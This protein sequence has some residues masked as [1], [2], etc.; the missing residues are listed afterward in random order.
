MSEYGFR[1]LQASD[2]HLEQPIRG[3]TEIPDHLRDVIIDAPLVAA[4]R[5]F[6]TALRERVDFVILSGD[7]V[8]PRLAGPRAVAALVSSFERLNEAGIA[9]Y[10]AGGGV[11]PPD[12]WP[13]AARL[14]SG[15][16]VFPRSMT[17]EFT[18][19][20]SDKPIATILGRSADASIK[21]TPSDFQS[22]AGHLFN[23][24][25]LHGEYELS[26]LSRDHIDF[27]AMGGRHEQ[28]TLRDT[29]PVHYTGTS[30]ARSPKETG[31]RG[32]TIIHVDADRRVRTTFCPTDA[33]RFFH[34]V[35]ELDDASTKAELE[36]E[37]ISR[38]QSIQT[39]CGRPAMTTWE[40]RG[41]SQVVP[42]GKQRQLAGELTDMLRTRFGKGATPVWTIDFEFAHEPLPA[43]WHDEDSLLGD[44]VR[45]VRDHGQ[46][47]TDW[48][49]VVPAGVVWPDAFESGLPASTDQP[50][51]EARM[52]QASVLGAQLLSGELPISAVKEQ[53]RKVAGI[54]GKELPA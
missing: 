2:L 51:W 50:T 11:D 38:C 8:A 4:Q 39:H 49:Q 35:I 47:Y 23:I 53:V 42:L 54:S 15:V 44:Y 34:E 52:Q 16:Q 18:H 30:Q 28:A 32:C 45:L 9:V 26:T 20:R 5:V 25:V 10:W 46:N 1:F 31:P 48:S 29:R 33:I 21:W 40:L 7:I 17:E 6:D 36:K 24:V 14:P 43:A 27:W 13:T 22:E 19:I 37:L 3:L 12:H 41:S